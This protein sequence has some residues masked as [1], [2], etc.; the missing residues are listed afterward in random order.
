[1][2]GPRSPW[3]PRLSDG[4]PRARR[5]DRQHLR[6]GAL[7]WEAEVGAN[8]PLASGSCAGSPASG[9]RDRCT[10]VTCQGLRT[11]LSNVFYLLKPSRGQRGPMWRAV[12]RLPAP[13]PAWGPPGARAAGAA[14]QVAEPPSISTP[15]AR[16]EDQLPGPEAAIPWALP[17]ALLRAVGSPAHLGPPRARLVVRGGAAPPPS[18]SCSPLRHSGCRSLPRDAQG[19]PHSSRCPVW[20]DL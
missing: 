9:G 3:P 17:T 16:A 6:T 11:L 15:V 12:G 4:A 2:G 18:A 7:A 14:P 20:G 10:A 13:R 5:G 1:M 19:S 8:A